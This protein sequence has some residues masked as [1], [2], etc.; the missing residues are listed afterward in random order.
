MTLD[1]S[2]SKVAHDYAVDQASFTRD[3]VRFSLAARGLYVRGGQG[4]EYSI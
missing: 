3:G 1:D 4:N 2:L